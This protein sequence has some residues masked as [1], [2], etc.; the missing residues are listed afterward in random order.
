MWHPRPRETAFLKVPFAAF[1]SPLVL[2]KL[3]FF[4]APF[5]K[6]ID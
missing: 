1:A 5:V 4:R 6:F 3:S 2:A